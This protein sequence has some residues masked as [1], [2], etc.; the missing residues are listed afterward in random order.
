MEMSYSLFG[1][2]YVSSF[3]FLFHLTFYFHKNF[4]INIISIQYRH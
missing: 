2:D 3:L 1:L 4:V